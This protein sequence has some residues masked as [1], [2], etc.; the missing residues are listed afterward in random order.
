M[1]VFT[2]T[3]GCNP[4]NLPDGSSVGTVKDKDGNVYNTVKIGTQVW[5]VENLKTTT[6]N[7]GTAIQLVTDFPAWRNLSTP[8]YCWFNNNSTYKNKY[9]ALYNW[10]AVGTGKLAPTGWHVPTE[11]EWEKLNNYVT[12]KFGNSGAAKALA[13]TTDWNAWSDVGSIGNDLSKNNS[14]GFSA[15][16]GGYRFYNDV[17]GFG[18]FGDGGR[19]WSS[20]ASNIAAWDWELFCD[21]TILYGGGDA[22]MEKQNGLSVRCVKD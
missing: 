16:P 21:F 3:T 4:E 22:Y 5:M 11:A 1:I 18:N 14:T 12:S 13:A 2:L 9:G 8:G 17:Q 6:Y 10:Y 7:D 19:W 15:L 20:S